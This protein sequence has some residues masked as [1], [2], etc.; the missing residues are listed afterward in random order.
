METNSKDYKPYTIKW[1]SDEGEVSNRLI[2]GMRWY[3]VIEM[4]DKDSKG[5]SIEIW[6]RPRKDDVNEE[7][8]YSRLSYR[9]QSELDKM[10]HEMT[11][12]AKSMVS[13]YSKNPSELSGSVDVEA[14][15][16][17]GDGYVIHENS[18]LL[19]SSYN[20]EVEAV[21][22]KYEIDANGLV[23]CDESGNPIVVELKLPKLK[24]VSDK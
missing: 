22:S 20:D 21:K 15:K 19:N 2:D 3:G 4:A 10:V 17:K 23:R 16:V 13:D 14:G 18:P 9:R 1:I 7:L 24:K 8:L 6:T 5:R 11:D 12:E